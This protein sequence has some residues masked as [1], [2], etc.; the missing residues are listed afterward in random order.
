MKWRFTIIDRDSANH[1]IDEPVGFDGLEISIKRDPDLHGVFFDYQNNDFEFTGLARRI[2][3]K[4]YETYGVEGKMTLV[5]EEACE[6]GP[7]LELYRGRILFAKYDST[8][9]SECSVKIPIETTSDVMTLRNRWDQKVDLNSLV[10]FD[11]VTQLTP[12]SKLGFNLVLPSKGIP[13][14]DYAYND[15]INSTPVT[16]VPQPAYGMISPGVNINKASEIGSFIPETEPLYDRVDDDNTDP[17]TGPIINSGLGFETSFVWP[18]FL[19]PIV[20]FHSDSPNYGAVNDPCN[21]GYR[22]KG[23]LKTIHPTSNLD[24][25]F[26][27]VYAI[28]CIL[29]EGKVGES[30]SDYNW[31][32]VQ[33]IANTNPG[34][35]EYPRDL[36]FDVSFNT[37]ITLQK[38][39]RIYWFMPLF[40]IKSF[41][42]EFD[43]E[44][45]FKLDTISKVPP[46]KAKVFLINEAFSRIAEGI[47]DNRIKAYSTYFGRTDSQPYKVGT[48]GCGGLEAITQ[49]LYIRQQEE[50]NGPALMN[51]SLKDM[52]E[53]TDPIHH[54]GMGI[55]KDDKRF[56]FNRMRIEHWKYFYQE[57][58]LMECVAVDKIRK[59]V[60]ES[61]HYSTFKCGYEKWEAEQYTGLDEFLT[62]RSF[63]TTLTQIKNDLPKISKF[64]ASGYAWEV[65][66]RK[67]ID[68]KDWR[69]D[70]DNFIVCLIKLNTHPYTATV[71][72]HTLL[73]TQDQADGPVDPA[74]YHVG[75]QIQIVG[76]A[77]DGVTTNIVAVAPSGNGLLIT[78]AATLVPEGFTVIDLTN[79]TQFTY[80]VEQG[81]IDTPQNIIDPG[82]IYNF[83][84]SP[85][86]NAMRWIDKLFAGYRKISPANKLI[87]MDGDGNYNASGKLDSLS[88]RIENAAITEK[89]DIDIT[90]FASQNKAKPILRPERDEY[91]YPM[92]VKDFRT[93]QKNPLG[94][95]AYSNDC[96]ASVGWIDEIKYRPKEGK[97]IYKLI[98]AYTINPGDTHLRY[99][100]ATED[101]VLIDSEPDQQILL[102]E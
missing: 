14:Q 67:G 43:P 73:I 42:V 94:K 68:S 46:T 48:D 72:E 27:K 77:N 61:E 85:E 10:S 60:I 13:I 23:R 101:Y 78:V 70:N 41:T 2:I 20:N 9:G 75:D 80:A 29:P 95:I 26:S 69:Y 21:L 96:E 54:I 51:V 35:P 87:F 31:L 36:E 38:G 99:G 22:L 17:S 76:G 47:T 66:R 81:L 40:T 100:I 52:W 15:K 16:P 28:C 8:C 65:T 7:L 62:K 55:E 57:K 89:Q 11:K 64:I 93:L 32:N 74:L 45:F 91:E 98:P 19:S 37:L 58:L 71:E 24:H 84:I 79:L 82:T 53:G 97:A 92:S 33:R 6:G 12:Y 5:I 34:S 86:R 30:E 90:M 49:G 39:D 50:R 44:T 83:R 18:L 63:R 102:T 3:M 1:L 56:G 25:A 59:T 4:E 88:C